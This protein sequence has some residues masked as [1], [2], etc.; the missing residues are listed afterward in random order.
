MPVNILVGVLSVVVALVLY[1]IGAWGAFRAKGVARKHAILLWVGFFFDV[2]AT[3]MMA[4]QIGGFE[5]SLHT[6][7]ALLAMAGML[8]AAAFGSWA[9]K[10]ADA[11]LSATVARWVLAPWALWAFVFVWG[12]A[13]RGSQRVGG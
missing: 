9:L 5:K 11:A 7:I 1:S 10:K 2:L 6:A 3:T 13:A 8:A 12:M 4:L